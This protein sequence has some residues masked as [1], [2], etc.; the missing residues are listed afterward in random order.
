MTTAH[1]GNVAVGVNTPKL[2][3][4][5]VLCSAI[6]ELE[7]NEL[8][9]MMSVQ[10]EQMDARSKRG[11]VKLI[12]KKTILSCYLDGVR[13]EALWD[14]GSMISV[15]D[16]TWVNSN[17][18]GKKVYSIDEI[19][20]ENTQFHA[21]NSTE[22]EINGVILL[23]FTLKDNL[24]GFVL[25]L[26]VTNQELS[27]PILGYNVI[28][29]LVLNGNKEEISMLKSCLIN[30]C[31]TKI[32]PMIALIEEKAKAP[33]LLGSIKVSASMDIPAG[34]CSQIKGKM[35]ILMDND[36]QTIHFVPKITE[37]FDDCLTFSGK[38]FKN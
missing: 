29:H 26:L 1:V 7:K 2:K 34:S 33:D 16:K 35:K 6:D 4:C 10:E 5:C 27:N 23:Y 11:F 15:V 32:E 21:A 37:S 30:T 31:Q 13:F 20:D 36:T 24:E 3:C 19:L 8:N 22:I 12:G 14:T 18:P 25:P 28:E 17:F 9:K 38:Y